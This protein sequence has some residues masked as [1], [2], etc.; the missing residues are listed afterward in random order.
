[1]HKEKIAVLEEF[2]MARLTE[3]PANKIIKQMTDGLNSAKTQAFGRTGEGPHVQNAVFQ[4]VLGRDALLREAAHHD[5]VCSHME[6]VVG[7][8]DPAALLP[9]DVA[10]HS[11]LRVFASTLVAVHRRSC[12]SRLPHDILAM[13]APIRHVANPDF[14]ARRAM[15]Y[16]AVLMRE[17]RLEPQP[18]TRCHRASWEDDAMMVAQHKVCASAIILLKGHGDTRL[19]LPPP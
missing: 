17:A 13:K 4:R 12:P 8:E 2:V 11:K 7:C 9:A 16:C 19:T 10:M 3:G 6:R 18:H 15:F 5:S 1:M 14:T